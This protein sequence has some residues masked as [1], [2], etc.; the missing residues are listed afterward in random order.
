MELVYKE[1]KFMQNEVLAI[2]GNPKVGISDRGIACLMFATYVNESIV[3][4]HWFS[5]EESKKII[6]DAKVT[7]VK[8]LEGMPCWV[9]H[10]GNIQRFLRVWKQ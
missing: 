1:R 9:I 7:D 6:E 3:A 10:D 5:W 4:S 2:I 8:H